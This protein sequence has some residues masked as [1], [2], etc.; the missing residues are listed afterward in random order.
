MGL[1]DAIRGALGGGS[2]GDEP[3]PEADDAPAQTSDGS[4][5]DAASARGTSAEADADPPADP[6]ALVTAFAGA[7]G[8][9]QSSLGFELA[10]RVTRSP[11]DF[12]PRASE[13][14]DWL[15]GPGA[16]S[17]V[18]ATAFAQF[19]V[20]DPDVAAAH[21]AALVAALGH[22]DDATRDNAAGAL[23]ALARDRPTAVDPLVS[24]LEDGGPGAW[25][26]AEVL[27]AVAA[28]RP[29]DVPVDRLT[30]L[31]DAADAAPRGTAAYVLA[32]RAA[33]TGADHR[34]ETGDYLDT[35]GD[36]VAA[37]ATGFASGE[38]LHDA[39]LAVF[40][41]AAPQADCRSVELAATP[42]GHQLVVEAA[43]P[44]PL[45]AEL[46]ADDAVTDT[47]EDRLGF[48]DPQIDVQEAD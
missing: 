30:A 29:A 37:D 24:A 26:A 33:E 15:D 5:R 7:S 41:Q 39:T 20:T 47:L 22:E 40:Q 44:R 34:V 19:A 10:A 14:A 17:W 1:L 2:D 31:L 8:G 13:L 38:L 16:R 11:E 36:V 3:P 43:D 46:G 21:E 32:V 18:A 28:S 45:V 35:V 27:A 48:D 9:R 42:T 4:D 6:G 25:P 12:A 23:A